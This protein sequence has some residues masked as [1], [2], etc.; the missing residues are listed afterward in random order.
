MEY[1]EGAVDGRKR[2]KGGCLEQSELSSNKLFL[3][4]L[5]LVLLKAW[6]AGMRC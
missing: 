4:S 5:C 6:L 2:K 1:C 3:E